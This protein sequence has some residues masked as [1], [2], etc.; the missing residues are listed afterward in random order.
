MISDHRPD[1]LTPILKEIKAFEE[2]LPQL[3]ERARARDPRIGILIRQALREVHHY[4]CPLGFR[5]DQAW[6]FVIAEKLQSPNK[7]MASWMLQQSARKKWQKLLEPAIAKAQGAASFTWL[8]QLGR[9]P[10]CAEKMTLQIVRLVASTREFIKDDDNLAFSRKQS[11]DAMKHLR[12]VKDDRREWLDALPI[13]QDV[14]PNGRALTV[15]ILWPV[16]AGF[17]ADPR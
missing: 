9:A 3:L 10:Q 16:D 7:T 11:T 4:H 13:Y 15:F 1:T 14:A 2:S 17:L 5:V 6:V 12:L 8:Q